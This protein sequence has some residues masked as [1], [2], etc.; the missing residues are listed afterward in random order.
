VNWIFCAIDSSVKRDNFDC[1]VFEL[2]DYLKKYARQNDA[3]GI[4]KTFVAIV[5]TEN[6]EV[7][8]YYSI[9]MAE[10]SHESLPESYS[11]KLP[12][13]P[14]PAMRL[15]KLAV[16]IELQGRGLGREL[17]V[18]ALYR[19]IHVSQEIGIFAVVVDA[20]D[21]KA[22]AFYLKYGFVPL[23]DRQLSLFIPISTVSKIFQ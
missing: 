23:A 16:A 14:I 7:V 18:D 1:G 11:K 5:S 9:S 3:K 13:Y 21:R 17:L 6:K 15:G 20:S 12:R 22:E 8:G 2:N 4:A 19:A 10:I